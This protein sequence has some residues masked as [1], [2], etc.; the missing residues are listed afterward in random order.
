MSTDGM[1]QRPNPPTA[2][3]APEAMPATA[4]AGEGTTLSMAR[5]Y[6]PGDCRG[7]PDHDRPP[8]NYTDVV[9]RLGL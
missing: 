6:R 3:E 9:R 8:G 7:D 4:S 2:M 5:P 1:P